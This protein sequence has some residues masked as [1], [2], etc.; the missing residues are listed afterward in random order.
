VRVER[1]EVHALLERHPSAGVS[2][3]AAISRKLRSAT[4][5]H[6]DSRSCKARIRLARAVLELAEDYGQVHQGGTLIRVNL[7]RIELG[8]LVG[9][10]QTTAER[11][12]RRLKTDGL[13]EDFRPRLLVPDVDAL[14]RVAWGT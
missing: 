13:V 2:L 10:G 8:T 3:A 1:E 5:R 14:R 7:T 9:V 11:A 12:L 4:R 6:V